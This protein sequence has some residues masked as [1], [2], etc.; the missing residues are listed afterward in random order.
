MCNEPSTL[1]PVH[2]VPNV[3]TFCTYGDLLVICTLVSPGPVPGSK[4]TKAPPV[5]RLV[6]YELAAPKVPSRPLTT[7]F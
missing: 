2:P 6:P 1:S 3:E 7:Y 5:G 4:L